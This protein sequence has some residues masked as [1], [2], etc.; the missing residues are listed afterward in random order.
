MKQLLLF[1]FLIS[2]GTEETKEQSGPLFE[3]GN[4][5]ITGLVVGDTCYGGY[6]LA[7]VEAVFDFYMANDI[8]MLDDD[9]SE[10]MKPILPPYKGIIEEDKI[11][12]KQ[13]YSSKNKYDE[14]VVVVLLYTVEVKEDNSIFG[15]HR[16]HSFLPK[17][18]NINCEFIY[19]YTGKLVEE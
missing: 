11:T 17:E 12:Y 8:Y 1:A 6:Y 14:E 5:N 13:S 4:Y 18:P 3:Q 16:L 9:P 2:C 15:L 7:K 10:T 19:R